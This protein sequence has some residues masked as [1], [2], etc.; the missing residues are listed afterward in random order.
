M[1]N[2]TRDDSGRFTEELTEQDIL[3]LFDES[4]E[5]FLTAPEIA[6][7]FS[8]TRQAVSQRLKRLEDEGLVES[9]KAGANAV[10]WWAVVAPR[11]SEEARQRADAADRENAVS[12]D[13]MKRRLGIDG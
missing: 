5:A 13:E 7:Q 10:G 8:V 11:L 2:R 1:S 6:D 3:K 9:K 4:E 12:Q